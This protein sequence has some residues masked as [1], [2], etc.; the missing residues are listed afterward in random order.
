[1][2]CLPTVKFH[3]H[4]GYATHQAFNYIGDASV[5]CIGNGIVSIACVLNNEYRFTFSLQPGTQWNMA[6]SNTYA[7]KITECG[8]ILMAAYRPV[9]C[10]SAKIHI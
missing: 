3:V 4:R 1:M 7:K 6:I 2:F 10:G 5:V 9:G 8:H